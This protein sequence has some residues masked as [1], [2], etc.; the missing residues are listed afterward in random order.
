MNAVNNQPNTSN[1]LTTEKQNIF[2]ENP[3]T[4]LTHANPST[5]EKSNLNPESTEN[6]NPNTQYFTNPQHPST[7]EGELN[8]S[9]NENITNPLQSENTTQEGETSQTEQ[10]EQDISLPESEFSENNAQPETPLDQEE[11]T[12]LKNKTEKLK[13][14]II[15]KQTIHFCIREDVF[16]LNMMQ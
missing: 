13:N 14:V 15:R 4:N 9:E 16:L 10:S 5:E 6:T 8:L 12:Q 7:P 2:E 11:T 3:L 1:V